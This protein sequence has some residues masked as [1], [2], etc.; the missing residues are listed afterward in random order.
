MIAI[1]TAETWGKAPSDY[2]FGDPL[3][4]SIDYYCA[5]VLADHKKALQKEA[6]EQ[7]AV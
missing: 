6:E 7:G 5:K 4:L 1:L 3:K 2:L